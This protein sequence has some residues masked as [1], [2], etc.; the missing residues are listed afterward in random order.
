MARAAEKMLETRKQTNAAQDKGAP[1]K[2][3]SGLFYK[4]K[5]QLKWERL[6]FKIPFTL[7]RRGK[8]KCF[9][10]LCIRIFA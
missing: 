9:K 2:A 8:K 1:V 5:L 7:P 4:L 6:V 3:V 10:R